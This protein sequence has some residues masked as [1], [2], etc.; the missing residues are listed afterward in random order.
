MDESGCEYVSV[1]HDHATKNHPGGIDNVS[2][3]EKEARM[4]STSD[5]QLFDGLNCLK[6]RS[7][8]PIRET[9][10]DTGKS[11]LVRQQTSGGQQ[12]CRNDVRYFQ[13]GISV[14]AIMLWSNTQVPL[15]HIMAI[16]RHRSESSLSTGGPNSHYKEVCN[17]TNI[18]KHLR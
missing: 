8:L 7:T 6:M 17:V 9:N 12:T 2:S 14:T 18:L 15:R 3:V 5:D 16:S 13:T 11:S 1:T 10:C 4:Y